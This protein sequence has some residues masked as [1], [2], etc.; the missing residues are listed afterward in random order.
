LERKVV[1]SIWQGRGER[2]IIEAIYNYDL[3]SIHRDNPVEENPGA[4]IG[5]LIYPDDAKDIE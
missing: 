3:K 5:A 4:S 1:I 2:Q